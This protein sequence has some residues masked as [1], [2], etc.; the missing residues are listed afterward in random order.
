[1]VVGVDVSKGRMDFAA[2]RP[3]E[4]SETRGVKQDREGYEELGGY[5]KEMEEAGHEVWVAFEPTGPYSA[6]LREWLMGNGYRAAQ[7]NPYHVRRTKEVRD[8]CP[9]K[10]D[11]KDALVMAGLVW[12]GFHQELIA[13]RGSCAELRSATANWSSLCRL[14]AR[15]RNEFQ[16]LPE[17]WFPDLGGLF[18]DK[19]CKTVRGI[20]RRH[21]ETGEIANCRLSAL[22]G[23]VRRAS[24]GK[25]S[26]RKAEE[27]R[28]PARD[29]IAV[30]WGRGERHRHMCRLLEMMEEVE[31][32]QR[33]LKEGMKRLPAELPEAENPLSVPYVGIITVAGMLGECGDLRGF[34]SHATL[35]KFLGL[36]LYEISS[37][38]RQ[39]RRHISKRGR[40]LARYLIRQ[41]ATLQMRQGALHHQ[42]HL[43]QKAKKQHPNQTRVA[44]ARNLLALL[45]ALARDR[46]PFDAARFF[47]GERAGDDQV[48]H[49]GV[50]A[51]AA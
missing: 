13:P 4:W 16:A 2:V 21:E 35:E 17:V 14:R 41:A 10:S 25:V 49:Q 11:R 9:Q 51:K 15:L 12:Q 42:F 28:S 5:L 47:T 6:C 44:I 48:I 32:H 29:S 43:A 27:I 50:Q 45:H 20:V 22:R 30:G 39:G 40:H 7:V 46:R 8:N 34:R 33:E 19:V 24:G 23:L 38:Q 3:G 26:P 1:M 18:R 31:Q 36:N 37:G